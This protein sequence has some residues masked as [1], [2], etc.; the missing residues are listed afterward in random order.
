MHTIHVLP[1]ILR[2]K[3]NQ[4]DIEMWSGNMIRG[5]FFFKN[6]A[7]NKAGRQVPVLFLLFLKA[8]YEVKVIG[9][10]LSFNIWL[11]STLAYS[12][13]KLYE[14][15]RR[16]FHR[17]IIDWLLIQAVF[18]HNQ[19]LETKIQLFW[20]RKHLSRWNKN[21]FFIFKGL[22]VAKNC[23]RSGSVPL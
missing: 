3:V 14:I 19:K 2:S 15:F 10:E 5:I 12:E 20:K 13:Y 11:T 6:H 22:L 8:F 4:P 17:L 16:W 23:L 7:E 21:F 18:I 1:N 9:L